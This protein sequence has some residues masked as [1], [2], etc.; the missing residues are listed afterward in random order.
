MDS[1]EKQVTEL[2]PSIFQ[3]G[4]LACLRELGTPFDH[5]SWTAP[6]PLVELPDPPMSYSP[7]LLP[8][9]NE[10]KYATQT[11]T[12]EEGYNVVLATANENARGKKMEVVGADGVEH[13]GKNQPEE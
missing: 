13:E 10:K 5:L 2:C 4:L 9:F 6:T 11:T 7:I 12:E 3:E 8:G 1:Y